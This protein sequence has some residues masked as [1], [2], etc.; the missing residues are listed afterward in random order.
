MPLEDKLDLLC[1]R[2]DELISTLR[3]FREHKAIEPSRDVAPPLPP[4][5]P[6]ERSRPALITIAEAAEL[7][8]CTPAAVR[9]WIYQRQLMP[10]KV[11]RLVRL[12]RGDIERVIKHGMPS[13]R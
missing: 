3:A 10:V 7:L 6:S 11:G 1:V 12:R 13:L 5:P 9:K 8:S 4:T 2:I